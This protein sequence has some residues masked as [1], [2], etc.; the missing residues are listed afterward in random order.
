MFSTYLAAFAVLVALA[1]MLIAAQAVRYSRQC[2]QWMAEYNTKA[3]VLKRMT[4]L[5]SELTLH[6]D[7]IDGVRKSM[8]KLRSRIHMRN[9]NSNAHDGPPDPE[10]DPAG[11][12]QYMNAQLATGKEQ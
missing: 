9:L 4:E 1:S 5:E 2:T 7:L 8:H 6:A 10:K 12:K 3:A 11:W